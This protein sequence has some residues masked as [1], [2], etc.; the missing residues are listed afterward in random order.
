MAIDKPAGFDSSLCY[1]PHHDIITSADQVAIYEPVLGDVNDDITHVLLH[2]RNYL[3]DNRIPPLGYKRSELPANP[4]EP[5]KS[6]ADVIG[7]DL[8]ADTDFA[9]GFTTDAG[10][11][12]KDTVTYQVD[13][14]GS[15]GPFTLEARLL[16]QSIRPSFVKGLH[17]DADIAG[18][19]FV[20][21]FKT[22]YDNVPP[23]PTV[24]ATATESFPQ[25]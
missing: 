7:V 8:T 12:G 13:V 15:T 11:D 22:M 10:A 19:S 9:S 16:Y 20:R 3:K 23:L 18:D 24:I 21:R 17:A 4:A 25:D 14:S 5:G 2:A 6:D 1:E